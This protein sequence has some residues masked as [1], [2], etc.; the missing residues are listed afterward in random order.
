MK[1]AFAAILL[2][3]IAVFSLTS[4]NKDKP[5]VNPTPTVT[6]TKQSIDIS[7]IVFED[8]RIF[9]G[10]ITGNAT[11]LVAENVPSTVFVEYTVKVK[12]DDGQLVDTDKRNFS[13]PGYYYF[14]CTIKSKENYE[15]LGSLTAT[16]EI[17]GTTQVDDLPWV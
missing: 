3:F 1:K 5:T 8:K 10:D 2:A 4:C 16:L 14:T 7:M 15:T 9:T 11:T 13:T 17:Y 12:N 6:P